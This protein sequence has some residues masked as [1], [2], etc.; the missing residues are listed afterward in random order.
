MIP[1]SCWWP[2]CCS[3]R[4]AAPRWGREWGGAVHASHGSMAA[5]MGLCRHS[6]AASGVKPLTNAGGSGFSA[7]LPAAPSRNNASSSA[8]PPSPPRSARSSGSC[9]RSAPPPRRP[10]RQTQPPSPP[11]SSRWGCSASAP[12]PFSSCPTTSCT[13]RWVGLAVRDEERHVTVRRR[14][15]WISGAKVSC[16]ALRCSGG[17]QLSCTASASMR[18]MLTTC[19][20]A[21]GEATVCCW[22]L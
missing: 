4:P 14:E 20:A 11:S 22:E 6:S 3:T 19:S 12:P 1:G 17:T 7:A 9:L 8:S 15:C 21:A 18:P 16:P 5:G 13:S 10:L 2:A